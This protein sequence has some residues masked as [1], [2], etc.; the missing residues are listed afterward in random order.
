MRPMQLSFEHVPARLCRLKKLKCCGGQQQQSRPTRVHFTMPTHCLTFWVA[1]KTS[2]VALR[3]SSVA[4]TAASKTSLLPLPAA[5]IKT[6]LRTAVSPDASI[7][8]SCR[9]WTKQVSDQ[10]LAHAF[11]SSP[12]V[13]YSKRLGQIS[14]VRTVTTSVLGLEYVEQDG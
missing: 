10:P 11:S 13:A 14:M 2:L 9:G 8:N 5:A 4:I 3:A 1:S 7:S 12:A 6:V